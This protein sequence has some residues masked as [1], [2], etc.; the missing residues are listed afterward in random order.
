LN[1]KIYYFRNKPELIIFKNLK[2][3]KKS[4]DISVLLYYINNTMK[5]HENLRIDF[6]SPVPIYAQVKRHIKYLILAGDL[7]KGDDLP[8]VRKL[9][10]FLRIN[11]NTVAKAY[12]E[13]VFEG[14]IDSRPGKG[15]W[16][17]ERKGENGERKKILKEEFEKF[18]EKAIKL[19]FSSEEIKEFLE[20]FIGGVNDRD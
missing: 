5:V 13:L 11:P 14:I 3:Y 16:V 20:N 8:S 17:K 10:A 9:A 19:G 4:L 18:I 1:R 2:K 15:F 7:K 6:S 12:R